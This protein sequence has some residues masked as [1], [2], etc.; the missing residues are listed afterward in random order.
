[1]S[2][3]AITAAILSSGLFDKHL[4]PRLSL[5]NLFRL[6]SLDRGFCHVLSSDAVWQVALA[7]TLPHRHHLA[8]S[9]QAADGQRSTMP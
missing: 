7:S 6:E 1:M 8:A 9:G 2:H 3:S 5:Q 4:F